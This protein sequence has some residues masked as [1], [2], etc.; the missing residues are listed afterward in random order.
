MLSVLQNTLGAA[1]NPKIYFVIK[2]TKWPVSADSGGAIVS[3]DIGLLVSVSNFFD[4]HVI[5]RALILPY[6]NTIH[7]P[8]GAPL[9]KLA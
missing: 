1:F 5:G 6:R 3:D 7:A 4:F 2:V 9:G 8:C